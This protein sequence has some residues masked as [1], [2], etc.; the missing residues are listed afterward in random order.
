MLWNLI[1]AD[2]LKLKRTNWLWL[3]IFGTMLITGIIIYGIISNSQSSDTDKIVTLCFIF[4]IFCFPIGVGILS[5]F[6]NKVDEDNWALLYTKNHRFRYFISKTVV[7]ALLSFFSLSLL[8]IGFIIPLLSLPQGQE[9]IFSLWMVFLV[10]Y[11][12]LFFLFPIF[13]ALSLFIRGSLVP[14]SI[15][16]L[17]YLAYPFVINMASYYSNNETAI[18]ILKVDK[19]ISDYL[20]Q[21]Q[22]D[23]EFFTKTFWKDW[24]IL[25]EEINNDLLFNFSKK[26][27]QIT[28]SL[29]SGKSKSLYIGMTYFLIFWAFWY[30]WMRRREIKT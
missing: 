28:Q 11:S 24:K 18:K 13:T 2:F 21:N 29:I 1:K 22:F 17:F 19:V 27:E 7:L 9:A 8:F 26:W 20:P 4:L 15:I 3:F 5:N 25:T 10:Y 23:K 14:V 16:L 12:L 30:V 6:I